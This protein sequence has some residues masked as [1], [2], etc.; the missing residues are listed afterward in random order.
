MSEPAPHQ[1]GEHGSEVGGN[2]VQFSRCLADPEIERRLT[3]AER[4]ALRRILAFGIDR[5]LRAVA[6]LEVL[7][8]VCPTARR[9]LAPE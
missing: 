7:E 2:I 9:E 6:N 8:T 3:S 5:V 1:N 4:A